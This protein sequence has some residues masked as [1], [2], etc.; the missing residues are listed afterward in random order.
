MAQVLSPLDLCPWR[1]AG[2][3]HP[4]QNPR[5][6]SNQNLGASRPKSTLQG[7]NNPFQ[8]NHKP[9]LPC[10]HM[11]T[12]FLISIGVRLHLAR[13]LRAFPASAS[14]RRLWL[15]E[16]LGVKTFRKGFESF[17]AP[18]ELFPISSA[19]RM[20]FRQVEAL[21][22]KENSSGTSGP[23]FGTAPG[24]SRKRSP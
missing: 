17:D 10:A 16:T 19:S 13:K 2:G 18:G 20:L 4:P 22:A 23:Q 9:L 12:E 14:S 24:F 11:Q 5:Q 15:C 8:K 6:N 7:S 1:R 21:G 3:K